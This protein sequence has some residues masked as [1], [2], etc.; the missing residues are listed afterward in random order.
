[1]T[2]PIDYRRRGQAVWLDS[3]SSKMIQSGQL[4]SR[5]E[6]GTIYGI[7][8]NPTIFGLA[9][10]NNEG[11]YNAAIARAAEGKDTFAIY[12]ELTEI[13]T[14]IFGDSGAEGWGWAQTA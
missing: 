6:S 5:I 14:L 3:I 10:K 9:I 1:M 4:A 12:D 2:A 7:T 8:S 13:G 11:E